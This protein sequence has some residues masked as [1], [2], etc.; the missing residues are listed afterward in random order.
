MEQSL[1]HVP[2]FVVDQSHV[3]VNYFHL[4][5]DEELGHPYKGLSLLELPSMLN[6]RLDLLDNGLT[7]NL[8]DGLYRFLVRV[9]GGRIL[10]LLI[11]NRK[12]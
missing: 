10:H 3:S 8:H 2:V 7:A 9:V 6:F 4:Q 5:L 11:I 1:V 12:Q